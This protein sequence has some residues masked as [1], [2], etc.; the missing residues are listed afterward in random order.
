MSRAFVLGS[1]VDTA[2]PAFVANETANRALAQELRDRITI[3]ALGGPEKTRARHVAR[4]KLPPHDRV[5]RLLDPESPVPGIA[6]LA[7]HGLHGK[8]VHDS[9][10]AGM[11]D[12]V[13]RVAG[14]A[15]VVVAND[16]TVKGSSYYPMTVKKQLRAQEV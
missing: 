5:A 9:P 1:A 3:A 14:R 10:G 6:L 4:G 12:G 7:P 2:G 13:G 8:D 15:V 16:A 11:S